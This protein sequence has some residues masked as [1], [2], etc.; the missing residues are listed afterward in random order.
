MSLV[1]TIIKEYVIASV[2]RMEQYVTRNWTLE[3][4]VTCSNTLLL[5]LQWAQGNLRQDRPTLGLNNV[6]I[7]DIMHSAYCKDQQCQKQCVSNVD[8]IGSGTN[9]ELC[10]KIRKVLIFT[11]FTYFGSERV[12][13]VCVNILSWKNCKIKKL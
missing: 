3:L 2:M 11:V 12:E 10:N 13:G 7:Y 6:H 1:I 5:Q 8:R 9:F 4:W